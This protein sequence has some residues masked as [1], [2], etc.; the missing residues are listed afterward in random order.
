MNDRPK[1]VSLQEAADL[2]GISYATTWRLWKQGRLSGIR[3]T[4]RNIRVN[5]ASV[6]AI[7]NGEDAA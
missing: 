5:V 1:M 2:L 4:E 6:D 7:L 3:I